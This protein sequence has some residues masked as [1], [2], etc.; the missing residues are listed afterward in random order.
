MSKPS[1]GYKLESAGWA[2]ATWR[3]G[4]TVEIAI[5]YL[6]DSLRD[7]AKSVIALENDQPALV[8]FMGEPGEH[9]LELSMCGGQI[10]YK[11]KWF[12]DWASWEIV[13]KDQFRLVSAGTMPFKHYKKQI[14]SI[15]RDIHDNIGVAKYKELW[16]EHEF[17]KAEFEI[18]CRAA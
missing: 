17:P 16:I 2:Q 6:H 4:Q 1:L 8:V 9:Q 11:L 3:D 13:P 10:D 5:S 14:S 18:V 15:L 7:L 12:D